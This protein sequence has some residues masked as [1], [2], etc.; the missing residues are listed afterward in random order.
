MS[1][2]ERS[3]RAVAGGPIVETIVTEGPDGRLHGNGSIIVSADASAWRPQDCAPILRRQ[4][5][6]ERA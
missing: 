5:F 3:A 6:R 1:E 2:I 4:L